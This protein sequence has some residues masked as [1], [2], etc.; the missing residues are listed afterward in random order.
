[1]EDLSILSW[2]LIAGAVA[3]TV[4]NAVNFLIARDDRQM[5]KHIRRLEAQRE[6]AK[7]QREHAK[8]LEAV[9]KELDREFPAAKA[10][11]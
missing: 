10:L 7:A 11:P 8:E 5:E 3:F 1:M 4:N 2:A 9:L 6:H